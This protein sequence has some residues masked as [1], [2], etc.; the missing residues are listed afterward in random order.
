M[1]ANAAPQSAAR[2]AE[3]FK[4][5]GMSLPPR[6]G[7]VVSLNRRYAAAKIVQIADVFQESMLATPGCA[8]FKYRP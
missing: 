8:P 2:A 3:I 5:W 4:R 1:I 7:P 6:E